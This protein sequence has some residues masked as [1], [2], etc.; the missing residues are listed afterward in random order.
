MPLPWLRIIDGVL[1]ATDVVRWVRGGQPSTEVAPSG[2]G[3]IGALETKLAGTV[4][5]ALKEVF[6]RD[7]ER[8]E[9]E[10][11]LAEEARLRAERALR[12]ELLRQAGEREIAR[13][14]MLTGVAV[15]GLAGT[16]IL[17]ARLAAHAPL[18]RTLFA[19]GIIAFIVALAGSLS[20]Q[21]HVSKALGGGNDRV[22]AD[23]V[24]RSPG[25]NAALVAVLLAMLLVLGG[26]LFG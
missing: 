21:A 12:L 4:V 1:G 15:A 26:V 8:L 18:A 22:P 20:G 14:R 6:D 10:R 25:G 17:A 23:D 9:N 2:G 3:A 5:A 24:T 16:A 11:R 19:I 13:L 7:S